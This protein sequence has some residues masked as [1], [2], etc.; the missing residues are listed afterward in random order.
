MNK[1]I[2]KLDIMANNNTEEIKT[3]A[4][5][6]CR[7]CVAQDEELCSTCAADRHESLFYDEYGNYWGDI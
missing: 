4:N 1:E 7:I 3:C 2:N 5:E 6:K